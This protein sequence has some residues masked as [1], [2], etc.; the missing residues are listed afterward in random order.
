[1]PQTLYGEAAGLL[2]GAGQVATATANTAENVRQ[3]DMDVASKAA[4]NAMDLQKQKISEQ[5]AVQRQGMVGAQA[6]EQKL[7]ESKAKAEEER[8]KYDYENFFTM[9][10]EL[11]KVYE[12]VGVPVEVG[13]RYGTKE[14]MFAKDMA[15]EIYK[16]KVTGGKQDRVDERQ[17]KNL[18]ATYGAR[19]DKDPDVQKAFTEFNQADRASQVL[20]EGNPIGDSSVRVIA[21]RAAGEVGNLAK[22]EQEV[23]GGSPALY[24]WAKRNASRL[25][26]GKLDE[27]DRQYMTEL[28]DIYKEVS[29]SRIQKRHQYHAE[30]YARASGV[31]IGEALKDIGDIQTLG[32]PLLG[33]RM[34]SRNNS[35]SISQGSGL[36]DSEK[37][38]FA[39]L[40]KKFGGEK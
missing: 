5:G 33:Q 16:A 30:R 39:E 8:Q 4:A 9:S 40:D 2:Q 12:K 3:A 19:F 11:A 21:A 27:E 37:A 29:K 20:A 31:P 13:K 36:S 7:A 6:L 17:Q 10:P 15:T 35:S 32:I 22:N 38:E 23:F 1:M 24:T 14:M 26:T 25:A 18:L 34:Q 28:F